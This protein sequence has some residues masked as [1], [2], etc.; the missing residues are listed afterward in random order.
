MA[1]TGVTGDDAEDALEVPR[2]LVARTVNVYAVLLVSEATVQ[3]VE[4]VEHVAPPGLAVT[5]YPVIEEPPEDPA[6]HDT[7]A[8]VSP[9]VPDTEVGAE[10]AVAAT[11]SWGSLKSSTVT[12]PSD[13]ATPRSVTCVPITW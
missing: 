5:V 1:P 2:A 8:R 12:V 3:L 11:T 7:V 10:G 4:A 6:V 13:V 9:E